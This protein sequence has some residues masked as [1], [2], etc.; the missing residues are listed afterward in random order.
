M[1]KNVVTETSAGNKTTG[2]PLFNE[3]S[4]EECSRVYEIDA[5]QLRNCDHFSIRSTRPLLA[6]LPSKFPPG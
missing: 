1:F 5:T 4:R 6:A 3:E 2:I